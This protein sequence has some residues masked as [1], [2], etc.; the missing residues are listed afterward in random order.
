MTAVG[1]VTQKCVSTSLRTGLSAIRLSGALL[2]VEGRLV[3]RMLS[4][5]SIFTLSDLI[6][7]CERLFG[8]RLK[9]PEYEMLF[10]DTAVSVSCGNVVVRGE[11]LGSGLLVCST[12]VVDAVEVCAT[13][14]VGCD[15][16]HFGGD[17]SRFDLLCED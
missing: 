1:R 15:G 13:I 7:L 11:S 8:C 4:T 2:C 14:A 17:L 16:V 6:A 10:G 3:V 9:K 12:V 5:V